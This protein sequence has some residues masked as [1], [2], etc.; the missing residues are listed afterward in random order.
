[1]NI[2][3][4]MAHISMFENNS[5][6]I[7]KLNIYAKELN[8]EMMKLQELGC[9]S[10]LCNLVL[11][12]AIQKLQKE[13]LWYTNMRANAVTHELMSLKSGDSKE[14]RR[15][16]KSSDADKKNWMSSFKLGSINVE[17]DTTKKNYVSRDRS[18]EPIREDT[19]MLKDPN[20]GICTNFKKRKN[21]F[22]P[23]QKPSNVVID[24]NFNINK[25]QHSS[26]GGFG[27]NSCNMNFSNNH[28]T[29][30]TYQHSLETSKKPRLSWTLDLHRE[31]LRVVEEL[32][33]PAAATPKQIKKGMGIDSLTKN[34]IK[35]H[36]QKY[37]L[38]FQKKNLASNHALVAP[39]T[40]KSS[41]IG[42]GSQ[43]DKST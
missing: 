2:S 9:D 40:S 43:A 5:E 16:E 37:R 27:F 8:A 18:L 23:Y 28:V 39:S 21:A 34:E 17:S 7:E 4:L 42:Q 22:E 20:N 24:E 33:G 13:I 12:E 30:L 11:T 10:P 41:S 29:N 32:G 36:L 25:G 31:F 35:S 15:P 6:K 38:M 14:T 1:M 19:A 26:V 3:D